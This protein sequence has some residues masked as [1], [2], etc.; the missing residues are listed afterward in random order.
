LVAIV[1]GASPEGRARWTLR[2]LADRMVAL[3]CVESV[4][5]GAVR[6]T[7]KNELKPWLKKGWCLPEAP[8]AEF[9]AAMEDV[10]DVYHR[11]YDAECPVMC[12]DETSK[13]LIAEVRQ[14]LPAQPGRTAKYDS[15]YEQRGTAN[16]FMTD[17]A[18]ASCNSPLQELIGPTQNTEASIVAILFARCGIVADDSLRSDHRP[19][20]YKKPAHR[21]AGFPD[22]S[23]RE[24]QYAELS[25]LLPYCFGPAVKNPVCRLSLFAR[26]LLTILARN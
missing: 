23:L 11:P 13:Q 17:R 21:E 19:K 26:H 16:F 1:C 15:E 3:G 7:P 20:K 12:M 22:V 2:L 6:Q 24:R 8:S 25:Y 4:W 10:L 5:H 14:P 18:L 9:V